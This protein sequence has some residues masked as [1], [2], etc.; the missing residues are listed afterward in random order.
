MGKR[1]AACTW[2]VWRLVQGYG[3]GSVDGVI[4]PNSEIFYWLTAMF[5]QT[6]GA[7]LR[8][9]ATFMLTLPLGAVS[10]D[11][12]T[13]RQRWKAWRSAGTWLRACF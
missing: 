10:G 12:L 8:D 6:L 13:S 1:V 4:S 9:W 11:H 5:P 2:L 3:T 7:A